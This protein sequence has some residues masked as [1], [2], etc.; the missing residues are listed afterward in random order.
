MASSFF[1]RVRRMSQRPSLLPEFVQYNFSKLSNGGRP[2]RAL[3]GGIK[4]SGLSGFSE[5]HSCASFVAPEELQV[6]TNLKLGDGAIVDIGA[7]LGIVSIYL[8]KSFPER[9]MYAVEPNPTTYKSMRANLLLNECKN[10]HAI[11]MAIAGHDGNVV[12]NANPAHRGTASISAGNGRFDTP[13]T[14]LTL[15]SFIDRCCEGASVALLK[16]D[17]EGFEALVFGPGGSG[18]LGLRPAPIVY[19]EVCP[20]LALEKGFAADA[21]ARLLL[22]QGFRLHRIAPSG[23]LAAVDIAELPNVGL[24]NWVAISQ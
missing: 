11:E 24:E 6:L 17:V 22:S 23:T 10:V 13:V 9:T 21:A 7:N 8:A 3:P 18:I 4:I 19:F 15:D 14:C 2:V 12:F 5:F 16:V 20:A 1:T